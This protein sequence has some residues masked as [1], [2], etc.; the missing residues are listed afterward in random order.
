[1]QKTLHFK[2]KQRSRL[3]F[4]QGKVKIT[5]LIKKV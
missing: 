1:M 5:N 3:E 2:E 4:W